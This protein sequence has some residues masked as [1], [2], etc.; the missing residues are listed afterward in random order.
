M[1]K[2]INVINDCT[3]MFNEEIIETILQ[4]RGVKDADEFLNPSLEKYILPLEDL[5]NIDKAADVV[6]DAMKR[7]DVVGIYA[8][9]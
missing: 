8:D 9:V 5:K 3:G 7:G 2:E 1:K 4:S 6:L